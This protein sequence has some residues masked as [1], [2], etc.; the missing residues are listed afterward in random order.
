[1]VE[2]V[3]IK[4]VQMVSGLKS[5]D[6]AERCKELNI[7]TLTQRRKEQDLAQV[8]NIVHGID[9]LKKQNFS[10]WLAREELDKERIR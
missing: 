2:K 3:H 5:A 7:T 8:Y 4:A 6:Y 9:K 1:M 10:S